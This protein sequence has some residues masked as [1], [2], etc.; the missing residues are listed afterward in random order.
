MF[1]CFISLQ[2][3][4]QVPT[5]SLNIYQLLMQLFYIYRERCQHWRIC[6]KTLF[7]IKS[8]AEENNPIFVE[9]LTF[10]SL[11]T[12]LPFLSLYLL[13][14]PHSFSPIPSPSSTLS[15]HI[16]SIIALHLSLLH[17]TSPTPFFLSFLL[18]PTLFYSLCSSLLISFPVFS[19]FLLLSFIFILLSSLFFP[20]LIKHLLL[21]STFL[22]CFLIFCPF[23]RCSSFPFLLYSFLLFPF[24]H[25]FSSH[26]LIINPLVP[27]FFLICFRSSSSLL[28][29]FFFFLITFSFFL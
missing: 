17:P 3:F 22:F 20:F 15:V 1:V 5:L 27:I 24:L 29:L 26:F 28:F 21:I 14:L 10:L 2:S 12:F 8:A 4:A 11:F 16:F 6:R 25:Y 7:S 19:S 9:V 18:P 13:S 23:L